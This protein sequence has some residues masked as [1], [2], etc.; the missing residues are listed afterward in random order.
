[1]RSLDPKEHKEQDHYKVLGLSTLRFDATDNQIKQA[2]RQKVLKHHPDKRRGQGEVIISEDDYFTCITRAFENLSTPAKR[3]AYDSVDHT[4]NDKVPEAIKTVNTKIVDTK[5]ASKDFYKV[6]EDKI[7][8]AVKAANN[9]TPTNKKAVVK[10][11]DFYK[12]FRPVIEANSRWSTKQPAPKLGDKKTSRDEVDNFYK[13]WY[14]F[15]SWREY[16]YLDEDDKEQGT[17]R[18]ERRW[19]EKNNRVERAEKKKAEM[20]RIRKLVDNTYNSDP[21]IQKFIEDD[22]EEKAAKKRAKQEVG[23]MKREAVEKEVKDAEEKVRLEKEETEKIEKEKREKEKV[24]KVAMKRKLKNERRSLR[25]NSKECNYYSQ[26]DDGSEHVQNLV[27]VDRL[28]EYLSCENL[29]ALNEELSG[30]SKDE[31]RPLFLKAVLELNQRLEQESLSW[32]KTPS[33]KTAAG[34][35]EPRM[36]LGTLT[37]CTF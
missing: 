16:S 33:P 36:S 24:E 14:D 1:L 26:Q 37:N 3:R 27:D 17:D 9:K 15:E 18:E 25:T 4:F 21:R 20:K 11:K 30:K 10:D 6:F 8:E 35:Q 7:P 34:R 22:K 23:R 2:Y 29:A 32:L 31:G 5:K 12:V 28:C 19:I 13:F